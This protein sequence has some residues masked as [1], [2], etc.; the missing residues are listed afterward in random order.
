MNATF[1]SITSSG[2]A[3]LVERRRKFF[4]LQIFNT[5]VVSVIGFEDLSEERLNS[6]LYGDDM[7]FPSELIY[8][9]IP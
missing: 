5:D 8:A 4:S 3:L 1:V 9:Q 7:K 6:C 2:E